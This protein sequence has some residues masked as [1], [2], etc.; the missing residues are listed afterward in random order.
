MNLP[1]M[2]L[3][4]VL[5]LAS[6]AYRAHLVYGRKLFGVLLCVFA[7]LGPHVAIEFSFVCHMLPAAGFC[8]RAGDRGRVLEGVFAGEGRGVS[9]VGRNTGGKGGRSSRRRRVRNGEMGILLESAL[10]GEGF[11]VLATAVGAEE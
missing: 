6:L 7:V 2:P 11:F 4:I 3:E 5:P 8:D 10:L 1:Q 9:L